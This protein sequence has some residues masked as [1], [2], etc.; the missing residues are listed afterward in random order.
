M[1]KVKVKIVFK[2]NFRLL[3]ITG[4]T[5]IALIIIVAIVKVLSNIN[6]GSSS[7]YEPFIEIE[8]PIPPPPTI[9]FTVSKHEKKFLKELF[10]DCNLSGDKRQLV[11]AC[12]YSNSRLRN[13]AVSIAG[14]D[15]GSYN[16]GQICDIFDHCYNNW[17][18]V[19]DPK[20]NEIVE[21]ASNTISNGLN[22]DCD[23]FAVLVCS[24]V[25]S[26]GGE[27]RINFAYGQNGAHAFTEVNIG[28]TEVGDYI[29]KRYERVYDSSGI[30][31]R[32][33]KDGNKWLNLD[34]FAKHPGGKY[35][36]YTHG[37]TFYIIQQYCN[38]FTK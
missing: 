25:L 20:G 34:W 32:T 6:F 13:K 29:S 26:I 37:T 33:D 27:A 16:L 21:Y 1:I 14:K 28:K 12:N 23:D 11:E 3:K 5:L 22:G 19:N 15:A 4:L 38:D 36:D 8:E 2:S 7:S 35:F 31:T 9:D 18:Y 24:M 30:W 10:K 17:K